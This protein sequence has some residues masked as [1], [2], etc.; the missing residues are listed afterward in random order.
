MQCNALFNFVVE[1]GYC[2]N[3]LLEWIR[4]HFTQV[5]RFTEQIL[6]SEEPHSHSQFWP[7]VSIKLLKSRIFQKEF[8]LCIFESQG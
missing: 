6:L 5:D 3:Q 2:I 1:G 4:W 8:S 7:A